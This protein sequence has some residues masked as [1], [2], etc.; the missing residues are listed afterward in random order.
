MFMKRLQ[1]EQAVY[2]LTE[3][4]RD[5]GIPVNTPYSNRPLD[6]LTDAE[7]EAHC[8]TMQHQWKQVVK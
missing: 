1:F 7:L 8:R 4:L 3:M 6:T 5:V 2:A